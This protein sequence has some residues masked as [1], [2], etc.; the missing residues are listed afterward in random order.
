MDN[1][2][3]RLVSADTQPPPYSHTVPP[4]TAPPY[5]AT[6]EVLPSYQ[7]VVKDTSECP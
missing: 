2:H 6:E 4:Y 5:T 7:E 3:H 1:A